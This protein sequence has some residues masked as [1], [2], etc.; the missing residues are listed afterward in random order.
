MGMRQA[1]RGGGEAVGEV[2]GGGRG[3]VK[4]QAASDVTGVHIKGGRRPPLFIEC[5]LD[6]SEPYFP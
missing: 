3:G 4:H 1:R 2:S 5:R 6:E